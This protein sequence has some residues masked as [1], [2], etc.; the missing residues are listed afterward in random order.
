MDYSVLARSYNPLDLSDKLKR[1]L[2][3]FYKKDEFNDLSK[4]EL[5]K[6]FN[7]ALMKHYGGEEILKYRI[8]NF[9]RN[10]KYTAAFEVKANSSR[11]DFLII[12][13][14]TKCFE[15]KSKI[16]NLKRLKSQVTD[17]KDVFEYTTI[18]VDES[19]VTQVDQLLPDYYGIWYF[20][21][22]KR[23]IVRDAVLSPCLNAQAQV[24]LFTKRELRS[25]FKTVDKSEIVDNMDA[26]VVNSCLKEALTARYASRWNFIKENWNSILPIDLQFF[27]NT[28]ID[29]ELI[30]QA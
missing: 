1:T 5:H 10:K 4:P 15:I 24:N 9:F 22:S 19:H 23:I 25:Y 29:P 17:Y 2:V 8:A 27:Y 11:A 7:D 18:L 14:E 12:N 3:S 6:V 16:D 13:G 30:Y 28:N 21:G 20:K 26:D